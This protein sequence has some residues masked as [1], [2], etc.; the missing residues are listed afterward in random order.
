MS[1]S[2]RDPFRMFGS[3][4]ESLG[5]VR[6]WSGVSP[7]CLGVVRTPSGMSISGREAQS[8]CPGMVKRLSGMSGSGR[9]V[10]LDVREC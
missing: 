8:G 10:L 3:G 9:E 4:R 7:S 6:K 5:D 2:G 1:G